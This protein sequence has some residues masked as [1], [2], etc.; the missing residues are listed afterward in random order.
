MKN[1]TL[2]DIL[3]N[4]LEELRAA[5]AINGKEIYHDSFCITFPLFNSFLVSEVEN[6]A[7]YESKNAK[8]IRR[9]FNIDY[10][11][12]NKKD[13]QVVR[14]YVSQI[15]DLRLKRKRL[16]NILKFPEKST[17]SKQLQ[18]IIKDTVIELET[19]EHNCSPSLREIVSMACLHGDRYAEN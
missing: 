14:W 16:E 19:F 6:L 9:R 1:L 7:A 8:E 13:T 10:K 17:R 18:K 2:S 3:T 12:L 5:A 4:T 11:N 15:D